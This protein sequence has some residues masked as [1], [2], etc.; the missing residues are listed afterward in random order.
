ML[1]GAGIPEAGDDARLANWALLSFLV[2]PA[3]APPAAL[4]ALESLATRQPG[5]AFYL[6]DYAFALWRMGR[7]REAAAVADRLSDAEREAPDR[8]PFLAAIYAGAGQTGAARA[9]LRPRSVSR[10]GSCN[11]CAPGKP[12]ASRLGAE[13][14]RRWCWRC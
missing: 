11:G 13:Y 12:P 1:A 7:F 6:T 5:N 2:D 8:A 3:A 4:A 10:G 9:A 14:F